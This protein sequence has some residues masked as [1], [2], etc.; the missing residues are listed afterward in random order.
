MLFMRTTLT[1]D[2]DVIKQLNDLK[3]LRNTS[4]KQLV[5]EML[6]RGLNATDEQLTIHKDKMFSIEANNSGFVSGIDPQR[7]NQLSDEI[8]IDA[9]QSNK[10]DHR[11]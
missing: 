1:L 8:D 4:F 3:R 2:A 7:L 6:R 11:E 10:R 9:F 5:N